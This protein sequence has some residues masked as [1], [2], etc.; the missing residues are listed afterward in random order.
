MPLRWESS[1]PALHKKPETQKRAAWTRPL[2]CLDTQSLELRN[3]FLL[4]I[5]H[6]SHLWGLS[7]P[8]Q[9][10]K[11]M[12]AAGLRCDNPPRVEAALEGNGPR[13]PG[14]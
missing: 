12:P 9:H 3:T 7:Q 14:W 5:R 13:V 4:V 10:R 8:L 6:P 11:S 2:P 1:L